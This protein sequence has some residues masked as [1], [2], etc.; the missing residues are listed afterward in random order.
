MWS[1]PIFLLPSHDWAPLQQT[2]LP[3]PT[4]CYF[5]VGSVLLCLS[6]TSPLFPLSGLPLP[7]VSQGACE[8]L[9]GE[10]PCSPLLPS[11]VWGPEPMLSVEGVTGARALL[12]TLAA[13]PAGLCAH[14]PSPVSFL[15]LVMVRSCPSGLSLLVIWLSAQ[16]NLQHL[17]LSGLKY[18]V[19]H[20]SQENIHHLEMY[21][22][23][24]PAD[25]SGILTQK[26]CQCFSH[27][28]W[29]CLIG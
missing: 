25:T 13:N 24:R 27:C 29:E 8:P 11:T 19:L 6:P 22:T 9:E 16:T 12:P 4:K 15:P 26:V 14:V 10:V 1:S 2:L 28:F 20:M 18:L 21:S 5:Q 23:V 3:L 7:P 17:L